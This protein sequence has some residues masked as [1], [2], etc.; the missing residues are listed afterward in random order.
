MS[1]E[2]CEEREQEGKEKER[3]YERRRKEK[4][5]VR[6][7]ERGRRKGWKEKNG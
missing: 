1:R 5:S 4:V 3:R 6:V 2:G 7:G